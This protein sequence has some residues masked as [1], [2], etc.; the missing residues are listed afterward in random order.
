MPFVAQCFSAV[1]SKQDINLVLMEKK[2]RQ[3]EGEAFSQIR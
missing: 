2:R 3:N 1:I